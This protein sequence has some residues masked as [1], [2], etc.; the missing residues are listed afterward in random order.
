MEGFLSRTELLLGREGLRRL[1]RARVVVAGIGGVGSFAAEALA[2]SGVGHLTLIDDDVIAPSNVNRQIHATAGTLGQAKT[3]VMEARIRDINPEAGVKAVRAFLL[4]ENIPEILAEPCDYIVDAVDTVSA[5]I[6]LAVEAQ[7]RGIPIISCMGA[8]NKLDPTRFAVA[9]LYSTSVCPLCR[10]MR[11]ALRGRGVDA[12]EVVYST[13][14]PR[15]PLF[16]PQEDGPH[17]KRQIPGSVAF[18]PSV[19][20]LIAAGVVVRRIAGI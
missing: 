16:Q 11:R 8:G 19:A 4:P 7:R 9:D 13:E 14:E 15:A 20:G 18:V 1:A 10:V 17:T 6:A 12:L 5:K 3:S 2:R